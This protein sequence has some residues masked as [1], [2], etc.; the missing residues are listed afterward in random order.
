M[1]DSVLNHETVTLRWGEC[2]DEISSEDHKEMGVK[3]HSTGCRGGI[4]NVQ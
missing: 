3:D 2:L 4:E 1:E